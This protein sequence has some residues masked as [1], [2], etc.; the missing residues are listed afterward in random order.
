MPTVGGAVEAGE[1]GPPHRRG[2]TVVRTGLLVVG[3]LTVGVLGLVAFLRL[4]A[5]DSV[6]PLVVLDA[7]T[8]VSYLPAWIVAIG[9]LIARRWWL[10]AAAVVVAAAQVVFV[11]PELSAAS[12]VPA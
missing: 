11:V 4:V 8:L 6:E 5:W 7:L 3:W 9:A 2:P 12:P 10:V 1:N